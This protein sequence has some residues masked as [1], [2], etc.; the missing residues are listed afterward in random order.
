[1]DGLLPYVGEHG[2]RPCHKCPLPRGILPSWVFAEMTSHLQTHGRGS[3]LAAE[4]W[5]DFNCAQLACLSTWLFQFSPR[6]MI[7]SFS[8]YQPIP[9]CFRYDSTLP[10]TFS[11]RFLT[12][13]RCKSFEHTHIHTHTFVPSYLGKFILYQWYQTN[14]KRVEVFLFFVFLKE[15]IFYTW[16]WTGKGKKAKKLIK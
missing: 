6:Q 9:G 10:S 14:H 8:L 2:V 13:T 1:M 5:Y 4:N 3:C 11:C 7:R 15:D 12:L 16:M